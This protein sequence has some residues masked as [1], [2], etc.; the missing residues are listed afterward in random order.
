MSASLRLVVISISLTL[1]VAATSSGVS[2][3]VGIG[4]VGHHGRLLFDVLLPTSVASFVASVVTV[5]TVVA[6]ATATATTLTAVALIVVSLLTGLLGSLCLLELLELDLLLGLDVLI[7]RL[8]LGPSHLLVLEHVQEQLLNTLANNTNTFLS[9][10]RGG[11]DVPELIKDTIVVFLGDL[12]LGATLAATCLELFLNTG[13]DL[14]D[15]FDSSFDSVVKEAIWVEE[16]L[17]DRF[18]SVTS[19]EEARVELSDKLNVTEQLVLALHLVVSVVG[20]R[21]G[22]AGGLSLLLQL[23]KLFALEDLFEAATAVV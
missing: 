17:K 23:I 18:G 3:S 11:K 21:V 7:L 8:E 10:F 20:D 13:S 4:S 6:T 12:S 2:T 15:K 19:Q 22:L 14:F 9:L 16:V 5:V 1:G